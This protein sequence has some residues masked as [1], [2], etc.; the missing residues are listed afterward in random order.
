VSFCDPFLREA[1]RAWSLAGVYVLNDPF[2]SLASNKLSDI[3]L[4][5]RLAIPRPRTVLLS[6]INREEGT[7]EIAEEPDWEAVIGEVGLPCIVKPIDGYA[8]QDVHRIET[9]L[10]LVSRYEE[11]KD[12]R[13][14]LAQELVAWTGYYRAFC[15]G[16]R[17]VRIASWVPR[18]LDAGVYG[19]PD[20]ARLAGVGPF[21]E[22]KT[23]ELNAAVGL[24]FNSVEWC[25]TPDGRPVV[26]DSLNE[27]PDVRR[28]KLPPA[29]YEWIVDRFCACVR[30]RLAAGRPNRGTA[31]SGLPQAG[32]AAG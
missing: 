17:D 29:C 21:I 6:R 18:P 31:A 8:W 30:E 24:D 10:E 13:T 28:E 20:P 26:I 4:C 19:E 11:L 7:A 27:V 12:R 16:A 2:A 1:V 9:P 23:A 22:K 5:D 3:L 25:V 15:V 14:L 32:P